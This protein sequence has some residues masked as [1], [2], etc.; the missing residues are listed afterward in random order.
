MRRTHYLIY[1]TDGRNFDYDCE[2]AD[3]FWELL[4]E[5]G[6]GHVFL[7]LTNGTI[8]NFDNVVSF[9]KCS[10]PDCEGAGKEEE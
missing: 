9:E 8:I 1:T 2:D 5:L 4:K 10:R 3:K 6:D 7:R